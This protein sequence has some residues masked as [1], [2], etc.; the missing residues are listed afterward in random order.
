MKKARAY[1]RLR[2]KKHKTNISKRESAV[3]LRNSI[4]SKLHRMNL[5][6]LQLP[7]C[8]RCSPIV[9][10]KVFL[11][12]PSVHKYI[13]PLNMIK[14]HGVPR[15]HCQNLFYL[16]DYPSAAISDV[17]MGPFRGCR[18]ALMPH[19]AVSIILW[20]SWGTAQLKIVWH[21]I[22]VSYEMD[23]EAARPYS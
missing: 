15:L 19:R 1:S 2:E 20:L 13:L 18:Y 17:D 4:E 23:C 3:K 7:C 14:K 16:E 8:N 9:T 21:V 12:L 10:V 5:C 6:T 22:I 11:R